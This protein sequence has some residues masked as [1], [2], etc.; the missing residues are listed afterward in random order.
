MLTSVWSG[1]SSCWRLVPSPVLAQTAGSAL[2]KACQVW[3]A[4]VSDGGDGPDPAGGE[5]IRFS[6]SGS[7][8]TLTNNWSPTGGPTLDSPEDMAF[9]RNGDIVT[10][11]MGTTTGVSQ[12]VR[13]DSTTG[14]RTLVAAP[15]SVPAQPSMGPTR[16]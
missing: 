12:V 16:L 2:P 4:L 15:A 5:V 8:S 10:A 14:A 9:D 7:Q 11:D 6:T 13:I 3:E 1:A